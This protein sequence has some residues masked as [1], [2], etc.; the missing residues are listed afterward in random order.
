MELG[1]SRDRL[2]HILDGVNDQYL[3]GAGEDLAK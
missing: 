2:H 1:I 3:V